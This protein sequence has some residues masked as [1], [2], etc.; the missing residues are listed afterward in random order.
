MPTIHSASTRTLT[1]IHGNH[2]WKLGAGVSAYQ[3]NT[4]YDFYVNGEWDFYSGG[5]G[6]KN[7][8]ADF[9]LGI[10]SAYYQF[11][12]APSNIRS[13]SYY[14]FV[15]DEWRL[16]RNVSLNWG[17]RYEYS[18]PK[19]DTQGREFSVIPGVTTPSKVF[20]NAPIGMLFPGDPNAPRGVNF[21]DRKNWGPR[22]GF[23]WIREVTGRP[24]S[25]AVLALLRYPQRRRQP[26]VQRAV[27]VLWVR[28]GCTSIA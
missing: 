5:A 16:A 15:Q 10:P 23:A 19:F 1:Y 28:K 27:A 24:A 20:P 17:M 25:A 11:P 2:N 3:N 21:P 9:L 22:F 6:S 8:M 18:S 4:V 12:A 7:G 13:K 14:G 26:A